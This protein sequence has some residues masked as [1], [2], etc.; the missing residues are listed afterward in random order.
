MSAYKRKKRVL[1]TRN[2][3]VAII[4]ALVILAIA[5][6][7]FFFIRYRQTGSLHADASQSQVVISQPANMA[8]FQAGAPIEVHVNATGQ[9]PFTSTELWINGMLEGVQAGPPSGLTTLASSFSWIPPSSGNFSLVARAINQDNDTAVSSAVFVFINPA[10]TGSQP[11]SEA[12]KV[13]PVVYPASPAGNASPQPPASGDVQTPAVEWQGSPGDWLTDLT[14][15]SAPAAPELVVSADGC[16]IK[17]GIHDLSS[18]EEGFA[19]YRQ[20]TNSPDWVHVTDLASHPG[21]GWIVFQESNLNGGITYYVAAFNG[22]GEN[23][24]NL[25]LVNIDPQACSSAQPATQAPVLDLKVQNLSIGDGTANSYCYTSPGGKN[26]SRWPEFGFLTPVET[27]QVAPLLAKPLLLASLDDNGVNPGPQSMDLKLECWGWQGGKLISLG[28]I[29]KKIDLAN[30]QAIHVALTGIAFD[31]LPD[32]I[33]ALDY[34]TY[35]LEP[36][37]NSWMATYKDP[38]S[39]ENL[40]YVPESDQMP[41]IYAHITYDPKECREHILE[42]ADKETYCSPMPGF[43]AG[44]GGANPQPYLVWSVLD[45]KTRCKAYPEKECFS[46]N[47]WKGFA[48]KYPDPNDPGVHFYVKSLTYYNGGW[49]GGVGM[50]VDLGVQAWR[51]LPNFPMSDDAMCHNGGR[52]LEV[53]LDVN[54]SLGKITSSQGVGSWLTAPCPQPLGNTVDIQVYFNVMTLANI[55][56]DTAENVW[57]QFAARVNGQLGP[58]LI[59]GWWGGDKPA[60]C[61]WGQLCESGSSGGTNGYIG[62]MNAGTTYALSALSLCLEGPGSCDYNQLIIRYFQNNNKLVVT[63]RAGDELLLWSEVYDSEGAIC[64]ANEWVGPRSLEE[65]AATTNESHW[66]IQPEGAATCNLEVLLYARM[67]GNYS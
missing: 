11:V 38:Y 62:A 2:W 58:R 43:T 33:T 50:P 47:W 67:P 42:S 57:G 64:N 4:G 3:V 56:G 39:I 35:K 15:S 46:L 36:S 45:D 6:A 27:G 5:S 16:K 24:S 34:K 32:V 10:D 18:N 53:Y 51:I 29:N 14:A 9:K 65:W 61:A 40:G 48:K 19:L 12:G 37:I 60:G 30:P 54:T 1:F 22:K 63:L 28:S 13:H 17:L 8:E 55:D 49:S 44:P 66:L 52:I 59:M 26:W 23:S 31:I 25:A 7:T 21:K 20:T 41:P